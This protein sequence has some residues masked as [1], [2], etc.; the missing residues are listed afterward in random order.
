MRFPE[1]SFKIDGP[2]SP[3]SSSPLCV[4][5]S[6]L[7]PP[8][9]GRWNSMFKFGIIVKQITKLHGKMCAFKICEQLFKA[10]IARK[11]L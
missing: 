9:R 11:H 6:L 8:E 2:L 1:N 3:P 10:M 5:L 7:W 4:C